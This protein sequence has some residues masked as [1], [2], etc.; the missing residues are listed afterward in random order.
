MDKKY[1]KDADQAPLRIS[2]RGRGVFYP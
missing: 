1:K 2:A